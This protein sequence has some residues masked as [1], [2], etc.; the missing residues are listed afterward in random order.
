MKRRPQALPALLQ[1]TAANMTNHQTISQTSRGGS[2]NQSA[3]A[4][5][6]LPA[7]HAAPGYGQL[8]RPHTRMSMLPQS[9]TVLKDPSGPCTARAR[10]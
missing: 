4:E 6:E 2:T 9:V 3:T 8:V 7:S 1:Q 10:G 5:P